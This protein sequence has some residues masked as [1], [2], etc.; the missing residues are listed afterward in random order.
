[1]FGVEPFEE[2]IKRLVANGIR[3]V[4]L[5]GDHFTADS[6]LGVDHIK[7]V[8]EQHGVSVSGACGMY[9]GDNDLSSNNAYVRQRAL[10][11]IRAEIEIVAAL[12]G[13]YLIVVPSAV[14]RPVPVDSVEFQRSTETVRRCADEFAA[15]GIAAAVEPIR[16]AEVSLVHSVNEALRY[17]ERVSHSGIAHI[18]GDIYHMWVEEDHI[19]EAV[20]AC[21][22]RLV[23]LHLA[24]SNR[25]ALGSGMMDVDT[26]IMA[27]YLVGMNQP[28][29]FLTPEPL[30]AI[31]DPYVRGTQP[32]NAAEMDALVQETVSYFRAR[33]K[34]VRELI[35]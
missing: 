21:G 12:G 3:F 34:A 19:G 31:R 13:H 5:K 28:G 16:A 27:A 32:C 6:G 10:D 11:Y 29:R 23:N 1:M 25:G 18:N 33:E 17:I 30:G 7:E 24:D 22:D 15:A 4:E 14:G 26:V 9:T 20:I 8:L 2:S 35:A